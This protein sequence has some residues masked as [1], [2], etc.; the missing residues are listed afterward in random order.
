MRHHEL[1]ETQII[2]LRQ[3]HAVVRVLLDVSLNESV[4][5]VQFRGE[6]THTDRPRIRE[7]GPSERHVVLDVHAPADPDCLPLGRDQIPQRFHGELVSIS[8]MKD[9]VLVEGQPTVHR[10]PLNP[11][12]EV[13]CNFF[14]NSS[15]NLRSVPQ[16]L[17]I[18]QIALI[19]ERFHKSGAQFVELEHDHWAVDGAAP[20]SG[21]I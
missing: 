15:E 8:K 4:V 13:G 14:S 19:D 16:A 17:E 20:K 18:R 11:W 21:K 3:W 2:A 9:S 10:Y 5:R 1:E 6:R 12:I 7:D